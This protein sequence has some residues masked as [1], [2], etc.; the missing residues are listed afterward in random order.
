MRARKTPGQDVYISGEA[1]YCATETSSPVDHVASDFKH[2]RALTL[3]EIRFGH[4]SFEIVSTRNISSPAPA[5]PRGH[6]TTHGANS[7]V[8]VPFRLTTI[9]TM[10]T[11][12]SLTKG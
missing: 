12:S 11:M 7:Q 10:K 9:R 5:V 8:G 1:K 6:C 2:D 3:D 4:L